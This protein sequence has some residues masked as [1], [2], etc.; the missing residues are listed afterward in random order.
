MI[1]GIDIG[2]TTS[3]LGLVQDGRVI[4]H[5]RIPTTGHADEHAFAVA[6]AK[7]CRDLVAAQPPT[8][9]VQHPTSIGIGAPNG[10]QHTGSIDRAPNLPW[11]RD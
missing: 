10:N 5:S 4:A 6:L 7:A 3:K 8:S 1:I 11:K 9:N 2:G